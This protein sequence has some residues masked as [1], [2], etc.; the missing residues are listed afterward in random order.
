MRI[1][2]LAALAFSCFAA[3][4]AAQEPEWH[5]APISGG[6]LVYAQGAL[7]GTATWDQTCTPG[8]LIAGQGTLSV[9]YENGNTVSLTGAFLAG[10]PD[11][12]TRLLVFDPSGAQINEREVDFNMGCALI[13][14]ARPCTP[15]PR[16]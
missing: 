11:G 12:H 1:L 9:T 16:P 8:E 4:A 3:P 14:N 10:V 13:E 2:L 7:H 15:V 6:C 5:S